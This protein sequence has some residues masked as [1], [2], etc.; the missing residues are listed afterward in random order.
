[1][2]AIAA[3]LRLLKA[4][5]FRSLVTYSATGSLGK[6]P[7]IAR[8][9]GFDGTIIQGIWDP[10]SPEEWD[11]ALSQKSFADGY[12]IGNEG[13][14]VR[15]DAKTLA[16][17]MKAL[18]EL[19]GRPVTTSEPVDSYLYGPN[20]QWLVKESD[21]IF[22]LAHPFWAARVDVRRAIDWVVA[23]FDFLTAASTK[24][25][26]LKEAG[27]P[28]GGVPGFDEG[29]QVRFFSA[30]E[31]AGVP[32]F[33]FEAFDQPWKRLTFR[34]HDA[35]GHWGLYRVDGTPKRIIAWLKKRRTRQQ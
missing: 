24:L 34:L 5:G 23:R 19:T 9:L 25:I 3:D 13:L 26:V 32:F 21:W 12:C 17:K 29:S 14:G 22:P 16:R 30:L 4:A 7:E 6:V 20:R 2:D 8:R 15:Y 31:S 33:Y 10:N 27:V 18:R 11:R 35:E 1:M 28:T